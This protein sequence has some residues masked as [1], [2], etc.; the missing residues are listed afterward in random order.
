MKGN[1]RITHDNQVMQLARM[2]E[3]AAARGFVGLL[4]INKAKSDKEKD[5]EILITGIPLPLK[6]KYLNS[7]PFK[8]GG[9]K[10]KASNSGGTG[11]AGRRKKN[12]RFPS[13]IR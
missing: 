6:G 10:K 2:K 12:P 5:E 11:R 13:A 1:D 3:D 9:N 7:T 8:F 4:I